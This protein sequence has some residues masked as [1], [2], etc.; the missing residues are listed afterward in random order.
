MAEAELYLTLS[1][2]CNFE[3]AHCVTRS[4][5]RLKNTVMSREEIKK[6]A[7]YVNQS[8]HITGVHFSGGEPT[9]TID[10]IRFLQDKIKKEVQ[11]IMTTNGW[12]GSKNG[13]ILDR[14]RLHKLVIS[15]D[16]FRSP[17][18][19]KE[20]I[21]QALRESLARR[22]ET[23]IKITMVDEQDF[24]FI[25]DFQVEGVS[26]DVQ[27]VIR[28]GRF[29]DGEASAAEGAKNVQTP[30]LNK[31]QSG[32]RWARSV[33]PSLAERANRKERIVYISKRGFTPCCGPLAHD[34]EA[35]PE[36]I[37]NNFDTNENRIRK[38]FK[39]ES[40]GNTF[41]RLKIE[42]GHLNFQSVCD[43]C[44][45]LHKENRESNLPSL[46]EVLSE[47]I[48]HEV[49]YP[50]TN[51]LDL[52]IERAISLHRELSYFYEG[53]VALLPKATA[54]DSPE[55]LSVITYSPDQKEKLLQFFDKIF[56]GPYGQYLPTPVLAHYRSV[57]PEYAGSS[58]L[59]RA[60]YK[61]GQMVGFIA[62]KTD[63]KK[64][65][66]LG[67]AGLDKAVLTSQERAYIKNDWLMFFKPFQGFSLSARA[68][69]FNQKSIGYI[70]KLNMKPTRVRIGRLWGD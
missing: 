49:E 12:F 30:S 34:E 21:Q 4:G 56:T 57:M 8:S 37:F 47:T 61:Q 14:I 19:S 9:L 20:T 39:K 52:D 50:I 38:I 32:E 27:K 53:Q 3:C 43:A 22:I 68:N 24:S 36:L 45:F 60:Y 54:V 31:H 13:A 55:E 23:V 44:S 1:R 2:F 11:Y 35:K 51:R 18:V 16:R 28:V 40:L 69:S 48:D 58:G 42:T 64:N 10:L 15:Y 70:Q 66:H 33:C 25:D 62:T 65:I 59:T 7:E 63:S 26:L 5:P 17:F 41:S 6:V 46:Y 29:K 67:F